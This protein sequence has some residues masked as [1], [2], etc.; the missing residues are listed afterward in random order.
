MRKRNSALNASSSVSEAHWLHSVTTDYLK[1]VRQW[2]A[3]LTMM[4]SAPQHGYQAS[5]ECYENLPRLWVSQALP[6]LPLPGDIPE[7]YLSTSS[8]GSSTTGA[9]STTTNQGS[10]PWLERLMYWPRKQTA[11]TKEQSSIS[12]PATCR[13]ARKRSVP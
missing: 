4:S 5:L 6:S 11:S 2:S 13:S 3:L 1:L 12:K 8:S 10:F 9:S 7:T